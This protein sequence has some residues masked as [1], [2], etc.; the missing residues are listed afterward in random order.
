MA[1]SA[2]KEKETGLDLCRDSLRSFFIFGGVIFRVFA[3]F[4]IEIR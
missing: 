4:G 1:L 2:K 3:A